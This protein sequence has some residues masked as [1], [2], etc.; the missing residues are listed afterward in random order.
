MKNVL[1][2]IS[3]TSLLY[4]SQAQSVSYRIKENDVTDIKRINIQINPF[5]TDIYSGVNF[6]TIGAGASAEVSILK[7]IELKGEFRMAYLDGNSNRQELNGLTGLIQPTC[8]GGTKR[9]NYFEVGAALYFFN[10]TRTRNLKVVLHSSSG[11]GRT[12]TE[13]IVVPGNRRRMFGPRS[14]LFMY[15]TG[16]RIGENKFGSYAYRVTS[17]NDTM[18]VGSYATVDGS[19]VSYANTMVNSMVFYGGISLKSITNLIITAD[20][21]GTKKHTG[22]YDIYV[23]YLLCPYVSIKDVYSHGGQR[24]DVNH[25]SGG[26]M[27]S[28]WRV[29]VSYRSV[30]KFG[31]NYKFEFGKRPGLY[32]G[33]KADF[34]NNNINCVLSMGCNIPFSKKVRKE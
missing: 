30:N 1:F 20:G 18:H 3:L 29:G 10:W 17:G 23:D 31:F 6:A 22:V 21:Y 4:Y 28:G 33:D 13:S 26:F 9:S 19:D 12:Y 15:N 34:L 11:G 16:T 2:T 14:G 7:R 8:K 24:W 25:T 5:Y 32:F 27:A